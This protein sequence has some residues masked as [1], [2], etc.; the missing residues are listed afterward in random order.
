[1][2]KEIKIEKFTAFEELD[3]KLSKGINVLIGANGT[4][5]THLMKFLYGAMQL[6]DSRAEKSMDQIIQGLF[7]PDSL[8]RLVKRSVGNG[9]GSFMVVRQEDD[10]VE[11]KLRYELSTQGNSK[12]V[13]S[14]RNWSRDQR[15]NV[16]YIPIKDMLAN[17]QGSS[18]SM[19][20]G[21]FTSNLF[22]QT[23]FL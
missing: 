6:A 17:V 22:M 11:R 8:G 14:R 3:V 23:L 18:P 2:L 9:K 12:T 10:G 5:K 13:D 16:V 7:L 21:N 20:G 4:G 15:Y 1:M 19:I